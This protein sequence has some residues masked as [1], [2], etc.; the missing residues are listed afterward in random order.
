M[1]FVFMGG[2]AVGVAEALLDAGRRKKTVKVLGIVKLAEGDITQ[3]G[4]SRPGVSYPHHGCRG[5]GDVDRPGPVGPA[6]QDLVPV[7]GL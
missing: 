6:G 5:Q 1:A 3:S 4:F 2:F 7:R